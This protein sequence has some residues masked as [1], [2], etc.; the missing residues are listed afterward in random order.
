LYFSLRARDVRVLPV[1]GLAVLV[2]GFFVG[3]LLLRAGVFFEVD[4]ADAVF[5]PGV[6]FFV[7]FV[8]ETLFFPVLLLFAVFFLGFVAFLVDF[9]V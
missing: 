1:F 4:L 6:V 3:V 7:V 8:A 5:L 9:F 2:P